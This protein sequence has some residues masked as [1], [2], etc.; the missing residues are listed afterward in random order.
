[1]KIAHFADGDSIHWGFVVAEEVHPVTSAVDLLDAIADDV[2]LKALRSSA[3]APR[4]LSSVRLLAP[5]PRPPQFI[6][7][8]LNYRS[9]AEEAGFDVPTSPLTF[10]FYSSSIIA[11]GHPI[12]IPAQS[13]SVDWEAEL[14]IVIGKGG[15]DIPVDR[16]LDHIAGYTIVNDVSARDLQE[17]DG[18][19]GRAKGFDTFCPLGPALE[20]ELD[21]VGLSI[22]CAVNGDIKQDGNT[23][24]WSH[25]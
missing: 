4:P 15:R 10:P 8:G 21:P 12:E 9:H 5:I 23:D 19:W 16:A 14:A 3:G 6:G 24:P 13:N 11:P 17:K 22:T 20:T 2:V 7:V 18:Q 25:P 1:M